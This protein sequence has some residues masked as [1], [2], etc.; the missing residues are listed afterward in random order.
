MPKSG[1]YKIELFHQSFFFDPVL[2]DILSEETLEAYPSKKQISAYMYKTKDASK[3]VRL[4]YPLQLEP[5]HIIRYFDIE[6]PF[7][8]LVF[9][10]DP[11]FMMI[12]FGILMTYMMKAVPKDEMEEYQKQQSDQLKQCQ[13]Q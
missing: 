8:P 10:K 5:S 11:Y 1:S 12:G 4:V 13:P 6:E 9:I 2:V 3:G 7:N